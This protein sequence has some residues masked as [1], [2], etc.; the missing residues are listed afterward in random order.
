MA[1]ADRILKSYR[2][3]KFLITTKPGQTWSAV[4]MD[5]DDRTLSLLDVEVVAPDGTRTKA[6]GQIFLPRADVAYMQRA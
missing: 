3:D 2:R 5:V 4:V 6:D 1:R